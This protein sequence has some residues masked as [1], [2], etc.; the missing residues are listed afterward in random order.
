MLEV[1]NGNGKK[2]TRVKIDNIRPNE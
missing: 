1:R 2:R